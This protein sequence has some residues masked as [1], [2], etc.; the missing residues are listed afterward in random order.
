[1]SMANIYKCVTKN[2]EMPKNVEKAFRKGLGELR[3]KDY[4]AA[5]AEIKAVLGIN[6]RWSFTQY[7]DGKLSL[8]VVVREQI[9][10]TFRKYG[11]RQ[12]FGM[13]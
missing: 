9:A 13:A 6:N 7:A 10:A 1:M 2:K 8:D 12:P 5:V 4:A 3:R 11:V